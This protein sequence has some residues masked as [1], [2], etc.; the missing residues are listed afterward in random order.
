MSELNMPHYNLSAA[1][2]A[3]LAVRSLAGLPITFPTTTGVPEQMTGGFY[4]NF[5]Q[6]T[7][8]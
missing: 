3:F 5:K 4:H 8:E 1:G 7:G 2:Y 6:E